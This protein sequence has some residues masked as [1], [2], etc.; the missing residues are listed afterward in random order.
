MSF[1]LFIILN[2][3]LIQFSFS[4]LTGCQYKSEASQTS[5]NAPRTD[6]KYLTSADVNENKQKCFSL[7]HSDVLTGQCCYHV[8]DG[9]QYCIDK[10]AS[11]GITPTECPTASNIKNNCGMALYYQPKTKEVCT[12]ISLVNGYCCFVETNGHGTA[13]LKQDE[14]DEDE[15]NE[16]TDYMKD[17]FRNRLNL[18]PD[19]QIKSVQC[20]GFFMKYYGFLMIL[21][22]VIYI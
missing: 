14:I 13:C 2:L 10:D 4:A 5:S 11:S 12:D 3:A 1:I 16:I 6:D 15:K 17:Y 18:N 9:K 20:E 8:S 21:L 22:A 19:E 7:S